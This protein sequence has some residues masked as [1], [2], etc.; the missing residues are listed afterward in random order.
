MPLSGSPIRKLDPVRAQLRKRYARQQ[1]NA[2]LQKE[3]GE[4]KPE[5]PEPEEEKVPS[6]DPILVMEDEPE[7]VAKNH[8]DRSIT[9]ECPYC[10]KPEWKLKS[11]AG[12]KLH[13]SHCRLTHK[14]GRDVE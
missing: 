4:A 8:I 11:R 14:R 12:F 7:V 3:T 5:P 9:H 13:I 10:G 1:L 2:K 6:L